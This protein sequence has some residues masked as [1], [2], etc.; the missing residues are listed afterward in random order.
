MNMCLYISTGPPQITWS[1]GSINSFSLLPPDINRVNIE[2]L[3]MNVNLSTNLVG[4]W[5]KT[6]NSTVSQNVITFPIFHQSD[7]GLY[8]FYVNS[9]NGNQTLAIQIEISII[10]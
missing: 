4:R 1:I 9:W 7:E 2:V 6:D 3:T 10:G 5:Q 8:K